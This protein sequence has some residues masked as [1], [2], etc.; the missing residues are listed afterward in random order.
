MYTVTL[1]IGNHKLSKASY[2]QAEGRQISGYV[3]GSDTAQGL[4]GYF[5]EL[6]R[7]GKIVSS[8]LTDANG[9]YLFQ[10]LPASGNQILSVWP[11][12]DSELYYHQ[13]YLGAESASSATQIS[14]LLA[15]ANSINVTLERRPISGIC[16]QVTLFGGIPVPGIEVSAFSSN[17]MS[18]TSSMT[19]ENGQYTL[20]GLDTD[21]T[22][23]V[24][25]WY[26]AYQGEF[27]YLYSD[28]SVVNASQ[29]TKVTPA[30]PLTEQINI[31]IKKS[32]SISGK[33]KNNSLL[34]SNI[35]VNAWSELLQT[36]NGALSDENGHYTI[37]GLTGVS[38]GNDV[39][40]I[41][42]IQ[43]LSY[44]YQVYDQ[45]TSQ[46]LATPVLINRTNIDFNLKT[47]STISGKIV[48]SDNAP[49]SHVSVVAVS[50]KYDYK[51][52]SLSDFSGKYTINN[53]KPA[54]DYKVSIYTIGYLNQTHA[55]T[56]DV[57][58]NDISNVNFILDKG[59]VI[60]G[61][62]YIENFITPAKEGIWVNV[63]SDK[64][65]TG[66][67]SVTDEN[68]MYEIAGLLDT[69]DDYIISVRETGYMPAFYHSES[70]TYKVSK[71]QKV[72]P[73]S[74]SFDLV[75]K[76]NFK[77][78]GKLLFDNQI[79][80]DVR[81][82]V[83]G[84]AIQL[85]AS[86]R[87]ISSETNGSNYVLEGL[88]SGTYDLS[89]KSDIYAPTGKEDVVIDDADLYNINLTLE[90]YNR[91]ISGTIK[92]LKQ[93]KSA[94]VSAW[95]NNLQLGNDVF[96]SGTNNDLEFQISQLKPADDYKVQLLLSDKPNQ[97]Y[98]NQS[99]WNN[100]T[101]IDITDKNVS[102]IDFD[103]P[104]DT[105]VIKGKI[106]F[107]SNAQKGEKVQVEALSES[108]DL[109]QSISV[110]YTLNKVVSYEITNLP[111][112][113][114]VIY[115]YSDTFKDLYYDNVSKLTKAQ[116]I[117]ARNDLIINNIDF[118]LTRGASIS[119]RVIDVNGNG[120][121]DIEVTSFSELTSSGRFSQTMGNGYYTIGGLENAVDF[122]IS[123]IKPN[124]APFYYNDE[125]TVRNTSQATLINL[126]NQNEVTGIIIN[127]SE[128]YSISGTVNTIDGVAVSGVW[129]KASSAINQIENSNITDE[130]GQFN[131]DG[132]IIG[133]DYVVSVVPSCSSSLVPGEK[134]NISTSGKSVNFYLDTGYKI[135]GY[136]TS[137]STGERL[138]QVN[139]KVFSDANTY[140]CTSTSDING[141]Y[142]LTGIP[143]SADYYLVAMPSD[144]S[145]Y[146]ISTMT[147]NNLNS[148]LPQNISLISALKITGYIYQAGSQSVVSNA[149]IKAHSQSMNFSAKAVSDDT[150]Y[151]QLKNLPE[152]YDYNITVEHDAYADQY[153]SDQ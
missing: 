94:T 90:K 11:P 140:F 113:T 126:S 146:Q 5:V 128:G 46:D 72:T 2:I 99:N 50:E 64:T 77:I 106:T 71:D 3:Y 57:R 30:Y 20:S 48:T 39:T 55:D 85:W 78:Y 51:F 18:G 112:S 105:I 9:K 16:G 26:E 42:E 141:T 135:S 22:Y 89:I 6:Q 27:Y 19:D 29:A 100:A 38:N 84:E 4:S 138:S 13:Y 98:Q 139:I 74:L 153:Q 33:V 54:D 130:N 150:G 40:Y 133:S 53:L 123:A 137:N 108:N 59:P 47:G 73:S 25:I 125:S 143:G 121:A 129:V 68:G 31:V 58:M 15:D 23:L 147:I 7:N 81:V 65:Q 88:L 60:S 61:T 32:G 136:V 97:F 37:S 122:K 111:K 62:V 83:W 114:Y 118:T 134:Q 149:T 43:P 28:E 21:S 101:Q 10:S 75:L 24:S 67:E 1:I 69:A 12:F 14:T 45:Q 76:T 44:P 115:I 52:S 119:G 95:S 152:A 36:G 66:G 41:V 34:L 86:T 107:P 103:I 70:T 96:L 17:L 87:S 145:G 82:E 127:L 132:L 80:S 110:V 91:I 35:W 120:V 142:A 93:G 56:F 117:D 116:V 92:G 131:I 49:A 102:G 79:V 148:D 104:A 151:Y 144:D 63:W 124:E 109:M 8:T